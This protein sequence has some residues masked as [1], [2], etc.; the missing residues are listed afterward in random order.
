MTPLAHRHEEESAR[1]LDARLWASV[2]L[3]LAITLVEFLGG[4]WA[5]SV[6]LLADAAHNFADAG[7]LGL[8]ILARRLGRCSPT[9]RHTYGFKRAEVMAALLNAAV[10][11]AVSVLIV[12]GAIARLSSPGHIHTST[13]LVTA[14]VALCANAASVL[15]LRSHS[16]EDINVRSAFLHL[17]QDALASLAVVIAAVFSRTRAGAYLDPLAAI[18]ISVVV[19]RSTAAILWGSLHTLLEA[20]PA[21]MDVERL[22]SSLAGQFP[23]IRFHHVHVWEIGPGQRALTAHMRVQLKYLRDAELRS[24]EVRRFL[25][26]EWG[27]AHATLQSEADGCGTEGVLGAWT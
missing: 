19:L 15:L 20:A 13:M 23:D 18:L 12:R 24:T 10:L 26:E 17:L 2:V 4:L 25:Q 1:T 8:A 27:I 22:V 21:G 11:V 9:P 3:N 16:R 7:A 6:A 14:L 5:G